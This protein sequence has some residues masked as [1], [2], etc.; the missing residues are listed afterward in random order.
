MKKNIQSLQKTIIILSA[1]VC[2]VTLSQCKGCK[3]KTIE[4]PY[5]DVKLNPLFIIDPPI[6]TEVNISELKD[7][8]DF[9]N[10]L[11]EAVLPREK[12]KADVLALMVNDSN[13]IVLHDDG[14]NGDRIL[15]DGIFSTIMN[16]NTD[17]LGMFLNDRAKD[18]K[19]LIDKKQSLFKFAGRLQFP[20]EKNLL[21][22]LN[23]FAIEGRE[24]INFR[25]KVSLIPGLI[26]PLLSPVTETFK[27]NS[28]TVTDPLV[29]DD[30]SRTF[31]PC[32]NAGTAGGVWTFGKLMTDMANT[33]GATP[34]NFVL[35]WLN[36]WNAVQTVN[37]D[38]IPNRN[39][40]TIINNWH[41]LCGGPA[42]PLDV[43]KAPVI[44]KRTLE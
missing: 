36:T 33:S 44:L 9:G 41:T 27:H 23:R 28:L 14:K 15:G 30:P 13:K 20:V 4:N 18:A 3:D 24:K 22:S 5:A 42:A 19:Q 11:Y 1:I 40:N 43:N 38:N 25:N 29:I 6:A 26:I 2:L 39:I 35:N 31:N 7:P 12:I 37:S 34:E 21:A 8:N 10:L 32:T 17:S 16:I